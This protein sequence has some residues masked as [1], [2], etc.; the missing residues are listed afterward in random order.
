MMPTQA[1]DLETH[2][3]PRLGFS[4]ARKG[5]RGLPVVLLHGFTGSRQGLD[6]LSEC[7]KG[8][9]A[10]SVDL[11]GHGQSVLPI[12]TDIYTMHGCARE[13]I[14]AVRAAGV[15]RAH[16]F[17]YSMGGRV[18]LTAACHFPEAFAS[19]AVLGA[20]P[21][22]QDSH[23]RA[24]RAREDEALAA[25]IEEWGISFFVEE[26][27][28]K[29]LFATQKQ[30]L[31]R[32][33]SDRLRAERLHQDPHGLAASLRGMGSGVMPFLSPDRLASIQVPAL[34]LAG[35]LDSKFCAIGKSLAKSIPEAQFSSIDSAGH[36]AHLE[37]HE[38][39]AE[40]LNHFFSAAE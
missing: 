27:E 11:P 5:E 14:R 6:P 26:W 13:V 3:L 34:V 38:A 17:G 9:P 4:I 29:P 33:Q 25:R 24:E 23:A 20:S 10:V 8:R 37:R 36:A 35:S 19:I 30:H 1:L 40:C 39:V 31:N 15:E 28:A 32:E 22:I 7:L 2:K 21:G 12:D 18:A 16:W